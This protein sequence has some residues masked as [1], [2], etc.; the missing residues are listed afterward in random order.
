M[1]VLS[2]F[3]TKTVNDY[4]YGRLQC[5]ATFGIEFKPNKGFRRLFQTVNP[6]TNR[7][8]KPKLGTYHDLAYNYICPNTGHV[9]FGFMNIR[10][11]EDINKV[12]EFIT[13]YHAQLEL[14]EEMIKEIGSVCASCLRGNIGYTRI[15]DEVK[16]KEIFTPPFQK[17][18]EIFKTGNVNLFKDLYFDVEALKLIEL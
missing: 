1:Q 11:Y 2:V 18:L 6:K 7:V 10:G 15:S 4:P 8:N 13:K 3:E 17:S 12:A 9:L 5:E 16:F 14:S